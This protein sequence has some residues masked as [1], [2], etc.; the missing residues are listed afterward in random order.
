[1]ITRE[2]QSAN[3]GHAAPFALRVRMLDQCLR[4]N[5]PMKTTTN[6]YQKQRKTKANLIGGQ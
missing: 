1:M 5:I 2:T 4:L 6:P 3:G